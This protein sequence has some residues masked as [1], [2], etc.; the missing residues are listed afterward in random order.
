MGRRGGDGGV[1][2][3]GTG[4]Q[5]HGD[6]EVKGWRGQSRESKTDWVNN[7]LLRYLLEET[8]DHLLRIFSLC[9]GAGAQLSPSQR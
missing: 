8:I 3:M 5:F 9:L 2:V 1:A 7:H 6:R 4:W